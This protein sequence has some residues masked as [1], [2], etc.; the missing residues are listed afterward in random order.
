MQ[1]SR[2]S[3]NQ[4]MG[5]DRVDDRDTSAGEDVGHFADVSI[6]IRHVFDVRRG[7]KLLLCKKEGLCLRASEGIAFQTRFNDVQK[8]A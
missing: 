6:R 8:S 2:E 5:V 1:R 4:A 3:I 7:R